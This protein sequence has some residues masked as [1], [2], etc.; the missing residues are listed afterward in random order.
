MYILV[1]RFAETIH[2]CA[3]RTHTHTHAH[4]Y[5]LCTYCTNVVQERECIDECILYVQ[6]MDAKLMCLGSRSCPLAFWKGKTGHFH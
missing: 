4:P 3:G 2:L 1:I 5:I 6:Y